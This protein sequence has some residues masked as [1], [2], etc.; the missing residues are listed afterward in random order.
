MITF[1]FYTPTEKIP[2]HGDEILFIRK[3][4]HFGNDYFELSHGN[5]EFSWEELDENGEYTDNSTCYANG[6]ENNNLKDSHLKLCVLVSGGWGS[7]YFK[8]IVI[9][10]N[11]PFD[12]EGK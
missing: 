7:G 5:I 4:T 12:L 1:D 6:E 2:K 9:C 8:D 11:Y 3:I 10:W